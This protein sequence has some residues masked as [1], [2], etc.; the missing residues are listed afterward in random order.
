MNA[1]K[2]SDD[3]YGPDWYRIVDLKKWMC[4]DE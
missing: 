3:K 2:N 1:M 4:D